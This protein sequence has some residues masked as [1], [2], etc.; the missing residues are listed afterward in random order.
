MNGKS[1]WALPVAGLSLVW[2]LAGLAD[3]QMVQRLAMLGVLLGWA[4]IVAGPSGLNAAAPIA[5]VLV[6]T[7]PIWDALTTPLQHLTILASGGVLSL[8]GFEAVIRE[9]FITI[10]HGT[11]EVA[12]S[13]AGVNYLL[14]G[15]TISAVYAL[16]FFSRA[17]HK[18]A[19]VVGAAMLAIVGNWVRVATLVMIGHW[20]E[21]QSSLMESHAVFG[22]IVFSVALLPLFLLG[23]RLGRSD[24][25]RDHESQEPPHASTPRQAIRRIGIA[26]V[27]ACLG[28]ILYALIL[29][30][31]SSR[32][33]RATLTG[34]SP[35]SAWSGTDLETPSWLPGYSGY[36]EALFQAWNNGADTIE[37]LRLVYQEQ[38][39]GKELVSDQNRLAPDPQV[40]AARTI[41]P[42][43]ASG[44]RIGQA[45]V[46]SDTTP[47][48]VWWWF[49]VGGQ[50][51]P[52]RLR[53]KLLEMRAR[54]GSGTAS[55]LITVS[56][57]CAPDSCT[58]A[59]E[60][61]ATFVLGKR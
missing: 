12:G 16:L 40:L 47:V 37:V 7:I 8:W 39:Q 21:M 28:P 41:G 19:I 3:V 4:G 26:T 38:T 22:W 5:G 54:M 53:S 27:A 58:E 13:C 30:T 52:S 43:D 35:D 55:E 18:I 32:P 56:M 6:L 15:L 59:A 31:A 60:V 17:S 61:L 51:T 24:V 29:T 2:L 34:V 45:I 44:R 57:P 49:H 36:D 11:F 33:A 20:T 23:E 9:T 25:E 46:R 14:A 42:V 1:W 50:D 48:L 10:P